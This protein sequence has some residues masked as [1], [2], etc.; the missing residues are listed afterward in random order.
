MKTPALIYL[1]LSPQAP[2]TSESE[3]DERLDPSESMSESRTTKKGI[4]M[5]GISTLRKSGR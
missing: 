2:V 5:K 4:F 1:A 3:V